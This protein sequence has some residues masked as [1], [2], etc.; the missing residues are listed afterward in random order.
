MHA[1]IQDNQVEHR[2]EMPIKD[3]VYAAAYY[4]LQDGIVV[5]I[6]TE[7]PFEYSGNGIGSRLAEGVFD[8]IRQSGRRAV[9]RCEFMAN[10]IARHPE[11]RDVI[12]G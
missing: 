6:H 11:V 2:Y 9:V 3:D 1:S 8:A 12:T 10:Y 5:L 7:V 4:R